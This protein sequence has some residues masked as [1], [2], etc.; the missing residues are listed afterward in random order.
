MGACPAR[1]LPLS[2]PQTVWV[3]QKRC[4]FSWQLMNICI[5]NLD[6]ITCNIYKTYVYFYMYMYINTSTLHVLIFILICLYRVSQKNV[7][8]L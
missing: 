8:T 7:Y 5:Y 6:F 2:P 3:T 4:F 1:V